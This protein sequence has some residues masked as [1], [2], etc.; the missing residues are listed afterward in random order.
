V[1]WDVPSDRTVTFDEF[2]SVT[3][4][5]P[6]SAS[7]ELAEAS[8]V[9]ATVSVKVI[10]PVAEAE[11]KLPELIGEPLIDVCPLMLIPPKALTSAL[12][13]AKAGSAPETLALA[14]MPLPVAGGEKALSG[15]LLELLPEVD[16][17]LACACKV[18]EAFMIAPRADEETNAQLRIAT[19]AHLRRRMNP[20]GQTHSNLPAPEAQSTEIRLR[21]PTIIVRHVRPVHTG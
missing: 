11:A 20:P 6:C 1:N 2:F 5:P 19:A 14:K 8:R 3:P 15:G 13:L 16:D 17:A 12:T 9:S 21:H 7:V 4:T 18:P 10:V